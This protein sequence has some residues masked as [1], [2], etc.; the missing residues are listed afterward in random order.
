MIKNLKRI[1]KIF[2]V[3]AEL[4]LNVKKTKLFGVNVKENRIKRWV[5]VIHCGWA[6]LP[7][8]YLGLPL[9][10]KQYSKALRQPILDKVRTRLDSWKGKLLSFGGIISSIRSILVNLLVYFISLFPIS[11]SVADKLNKCIANFVWGAKSDRVIRWIK[12]DNICG[13]KS[14]GCLG[15]FDVKIRNRAMLNT[16]IWRYN[17]EDDSLWKKVVVGKYDYDPDSILQNVVNARN[18]SWVW[19]NIIAPSSSNVV[20]FASKLRCMMG[21]GNKIEFWFDHWTEM[22]SLK[23][24][25]PKIFGIVIKNMARLENSVIGI[26]E[27]GNGRLS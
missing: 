21:N 1:L 9:G 18:S 2:E 13:P 15:I 23:D 10:H 20:E 12:W 24:S 3:A 14:H 17:E 6:M 16:W 22:I 26:S 8:I 11:V 25:F 27:Y 7:T 4:K 19:R 5:D